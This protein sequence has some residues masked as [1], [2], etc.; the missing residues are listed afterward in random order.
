M[1]KIAWDYRDLNRALKDARRV[2]HTSVPS[3]V[4]WTS[5]QFLF[6]ARLATPGPRRGS[7]TTER[8]REII[9]NP[10]YK[11][12]KRG[13]RVSKYLI[14]SWQGKRSQPT[15][16]PTNSKRDKR[17]K[18]TTRGIAQ[19]GWTACFRKLGKQAKLNKAEKTGAKYA[20]VRSSL[21]TGPKAYAEMINAV[22]YVS[23][24]AS[25]AAKIGISKATSA[26]RS[27]MQK[28]L[29]KDLEKSFNR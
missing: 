6:S 26:L 18:I 4:K 12:R 10:D 9:H 14:V 7:K 13:Q 27:R 17:V 15:Y 16:I 28:R 25:D 20:S 11:T 2:L 3:L 29:A 8:K 5:Y 19:G 21:T 24:I 22:P 23:D 1:L